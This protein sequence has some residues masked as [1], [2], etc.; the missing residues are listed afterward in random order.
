M[1]LGVWKY[2][3]MVVKVSIFRQSMRNAGMWR[4]NIDG[5]ASRRDVRRC[6]VRNCQTGAVRRQQRWRCGRRAGSRPYSA[7]LTQ[8]ATSLSGPTGR[9]NAREPASPPPPPRRCPRSSN[10]ECQMLSHAT[11]RRAVRT[12]LRRS[13]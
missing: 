8:R 5:A 4:G 12:P 9:R 2:S 6:D 1:A 7:G 3:T 11:V 13:S 10:Y